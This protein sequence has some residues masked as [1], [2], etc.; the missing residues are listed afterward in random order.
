[1]FKFKH[2]TTSILFLLLT[3]TSSYADHNHRT[4]VIKEIL[5][6]VVEVVA[7]KD[8]APVNQENGFQFRNKK[9]GPNKEEMEQDQFHS[10]TGF[11]ITSDGYVVTNA[12]VINNV[13]IAGTITL[14]FY[15]DLTYSAKIIGYD[16]DSD[17]AL[18]KII[19]KRIGIEVPGEF[20]FVSWGKRPELGENT[21]AIGSP[22]NLSFSITRGIVSSID[23]F[24][25]NLPSYVPFIQT[26]ASI[27]PGNSG[28]PL[29]N[30]D[31]EVIG[32]NTLIISNN[33]DKQSSGS[34]GLGFAVD[35][36]FAQGVIEQLMTGEKIVR[37][38]MGIMYRVI[39]DTDMNDYTEGTGVIIQE[40]VPLSP[41]GDFLR[42]GDILLKMNGKDIKWRLLATQIKNKR[43]GEIVLFDIVRDGKHMKIEFKLGIKK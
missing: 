27:N 4:N 14:R 42:V 9:P 25:P 22:L 18:L 28:G 26:D 20:P 3:F 37:P 30:E 41:A 32:I 12:H 39:I 15:N 43:V 34:I 16:D 33:R 29:F 31:G 7:Q 17:L 36:V 2:I 21:I 11:V 35:G 40:I 38:Y 5:P 1:M 19:P 10:G 23:R 6:A 13:K 8:T 24:I